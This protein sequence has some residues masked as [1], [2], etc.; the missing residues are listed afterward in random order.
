MLTGERMLVL[1]LL[2]FSVTRMLSLLEDARLSTYVTF[3]FRERSVQ[4]VAEGSAR[5]NPEWRLPHACPEI[6]APL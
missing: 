2:R 6:G 3:F 5:M 1:V 4:L